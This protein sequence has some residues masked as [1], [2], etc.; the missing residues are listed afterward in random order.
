MVAGTQISMPPF[1][2]LIVFASIWVGF[3]L[4]HFKI[5]VLT[6]FTDLSMSEL[7]GQVVLEWTIGSIVVGAFLGV[8]MGTATSLALRLI[9]EKK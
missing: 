9:P 1:S 6:D 5:P 7:F 3:I 2:P 4:L 8:I